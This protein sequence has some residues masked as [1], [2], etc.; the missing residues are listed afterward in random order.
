MVACN[1]QAG[2]NTEK[3]VKTV[4]CTWI[5]AK[6]QGYMVCWQIKS[7]KCP[8]ANLFYLCAGQQKLY[9]SAASFLTVC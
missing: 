4:T 8:S 2:K 5:K 9:V 3:V 6:V 1:G 7:H